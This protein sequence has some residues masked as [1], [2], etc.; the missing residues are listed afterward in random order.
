MRRS[1]VLVAL[2]SVLVV[3]GLVGAS[4]ARAYPTSGASD[5][6]ARVVA[7][8]TVGRLAFVTN[9]GQVEIATVSANGTT[10]AP[11]V[12]GPITPSTAGDT[13]EIES[14]TS[15]ADGRWLA[16]TESKV[17]AATTSGA[18]QVHS[19]LVLRDLRSGHT[20]SLTSQTTPL[21][22][23][24]NTLVT[25]RY[26]QQGFRLKL[27]P[28][29]HL[30]RIRVHLRYPTILATNRTGIVVLTNPRASRD[31]LSIDRLSR[32]SF[33][34]VARTIHR[35]VHSSSSLAPLELAWTSPDGTQ[36]VVEHG[37]HTDFGGVGPSSRAD[38]LNP[39][40][41]SSPTALGH[42]GTAK[43]AWRM[44]QTTFAGKRNSI[45]TV[46]MTAHSSAP[47]PVVATYSHGSWH[48]V[49]N[50]A[51][52]VAGNRSG[53]VAVQPGKYVQDPAVDFPAYDIKAVG[54]AVL[55]HGGTRH[56]LSI[57]GT[58]LAWVS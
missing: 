1:Q 23:V 39:N 40:T 44:E 2:A 27:T 26:E 9:A 30:V 42:P 47:H 57:G 10:G 16:W 17:K 48:R 38:E 4:D 6:R 50:H 41:A 34:G 22:F 55:V 51:L 12:I 7:A 8:T 54:G 18:T 58:E 53:Y 21:G 20:F 15:S 49:L 28:K 3:V 29:P 45:Y 32:V 24:H 19:E 46:W 36:L 56:T 25:T 43:A 5:T 35:Y 14:L 52:V 11:K 33:G 31:S 13:I 37:D